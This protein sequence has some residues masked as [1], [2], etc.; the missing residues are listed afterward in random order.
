MATLFLL[1]LLLL[2]GARE[3]IAEYSCIRHPAQSSEAGPES[4]RHQRHLAL[5]SG[6]RQGTAVLEGT[7]SET[8]GGQGHGPGEVCS[9]IDSCWTTPGVAIASV[10]EARDSPDDGER[11]VTAGK[12]SPL[13]NAASKFLL[14]FPNGPPRHG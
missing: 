2:G 10:P 6:P 9:C 5:D 4:G 12:P 7:G 13:L 3:G 11:P 14:P 1:L 8:D